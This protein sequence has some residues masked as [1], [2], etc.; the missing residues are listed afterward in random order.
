MKRKSVKSLASN[1][2]VKRMRMGLFGRES[3]FR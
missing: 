1:A 3:S 2:I